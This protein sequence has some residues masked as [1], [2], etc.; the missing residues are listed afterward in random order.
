MRVDL[1]EFA[2]KAQEKA[3][4]SEDTIFTVSELTRQLKGLI[5]SRFGEHSFWVKGEVSNFKRHQSGHIYF[6]LKDSGAV[7]SCV[8]FRN[9]NRKLN[10]D[11]KDG[12]EILALG[13]LD[14]WEQGSNYQLV[15][16]EVRIGGRGELYLRFE[17]LKK[18]LEEEGL[19]DPQRKKK[20]PEFPQ[21]IGLI[22]SPTGAVI[23]DII[24]VVKKRCPFIQ[25]LL[26]PVRV[27]GDG[28][29]LEIVQAISEMND[30]SLG[31]ETLIVGRGGGSIEDLWA[32]NEEAVAR[33]I[34]AS[35]L[36]IISA[37]GHQTDFT[38]AD[39]V[40]DTRAATP[41]QA[42]ELAVPDVAQLLLRI[43]LLMENVV[44]EITHKK[45][46]VAQRLGRL[47]TSP[48]LKDPRSL[49]HA[50]AQRLDLAVE[51]LVD[52][53]KRRRDLDTEHVTWIKTQ[54]QLMLKQK[55]EPFK[56]RLEKILSNLNLLNPLAVLSRGYS[57]IRNREGKI[58]KRHGEVEVGENI[59]VLLHQGE[60]SCEITKIL[61]P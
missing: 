1:F 37:V 41:S 60:L 11:F 51:R 44:R 49:L 32:F 10:F 14:V 59:S 30:P 34:A 22:T 33:A 55:I 58:V 56:L 6:R 43:E 40:A 38:I 17:Q 36:P 18:R 9:A 20:L 19:F 2:E 27:Q 53:L 61:E 54:F 21:K 24:Q 16:E 3:K 23:Q 26:S 47:T 5:L 50:R 48:F 4:L 42:A 7:L 13:R 12:T 8:F 46:I 45:E 35:R 28:A 52:K 31:I 25:L 39:F 29:A 15:I 57:V